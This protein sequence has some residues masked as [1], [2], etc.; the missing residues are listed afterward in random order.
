MIKLTKMIFNH[1]N[2]VCINRY[3]AVTNDYVNKKE[4]K[5]FKTLIEWMLKKR[6]FTYSEFRSLIEENVA[7]ME[8]GTLRKFLNQNNEND[9]DEMKRMKR[10]L[11]CILPNEIKNPKLLGYKHIRDEILKVSG[12]GDTDFRKT[13]QTFENYKKIYELVKTRKRKELPIPE[14]QNELELIFRQEYKYTY[15][16]KKEMA[17]EYTETM[18]HMRK[19]HSK[20]EIAKKRDAARIRRLPYRLK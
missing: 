12:E 14:S 13:E 15:Y 11:C 7:S 20:K 2:P 17:D 10:I 6:Q 19:E 3:F 1:P 4:D 5:G 18:K 9:K 8:S 16:E